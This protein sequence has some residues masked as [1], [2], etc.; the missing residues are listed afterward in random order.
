MKRPFSIWSEGTFHVI[1]SIDWYKIWVLIDFNGFALIRRVSVSLIARK[2]VV[3]EFF[4]PRPSSL[5]HFWYLNWYLPHTVFR[6]RFWYLKQFRRYVITKF[7]LLKRDFRWHCR[8]NGYVN[9]HWE[10]TRQFQRD[11]LTKLAEMLKWCDNFQYIQQHLH[12]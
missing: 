4:D 3:F 12:G 2:L 7:E 5:V 9:F 6:I 8:Q 1:V 11:E 10:T